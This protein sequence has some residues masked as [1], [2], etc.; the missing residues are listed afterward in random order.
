MA[1]SDFYADLSK[2]EPTMANGTMTKKQVK[3]L[4]RI[5]PTMGLIAGFFILVPNVLGWLLTFVLSI[6]L[7]GPLLLKFTGYWGTV[8]HAYHFYMTI[9]HRHYDKNYSLRKESSDVS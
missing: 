2:F 8:V 1:S 3:L 5:V 7:L 4:I 9:K 6:V